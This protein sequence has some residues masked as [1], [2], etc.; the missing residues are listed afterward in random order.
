MLKFWRVEFFDYFCPMVRKVTVLV[1]LLWSF[2]AARAAASLDSLLNALDYEI[3]IA[4]AA[5]IEPKEAM[6]EN[7]RNI[8]EGVDNDKERFELLRRLH[9]EYLYF[10][11]DTAYNY[12]RR[13]ERT[14]MRMGDSVRISMARMALLEC[15][16]S[17][18]FFQE[19][20]KMVESIDI[21]LLPPKER[22]DC[23]LDIAKL[24]QNMESYVAG[25]D[26]LVRKYTERRRRC[27]NAVLALAD[28]DSYS[29]AMARVEKARISRYASPE[30]IT[31]CKNILERHKTDAHQKAINYSTIGLS[32]AILGN[33]DSA[34]YYITL[35]AI[36]DIRSNTRET[37][38]AKDLAGIML[39]R[40]DIE[41]AN[42]YINCALS[43]AET[44]NSRLRKVEINT[45]MPL[46]ET[47]RHNQIS[48]R[49]KQLIGVAIAITLLLALTAFL[50]FK[51]KK[52]NRILTQ[53]HLENREKA[54]ALEESNTALAEAITDLEEAKE[55]KDQY[56]IQSLYSNTDF[57]NEVEEKTKRALLKLKSKQYAEVTGILSDM[58]VRREQERMYSAFDNAFL[59]LFPNFIDELNRLMQP[60]HRIFLIDGKLPTEVRIFA[61]MRLGIDSPVQ[62]AQYL[63]LSVNTVY[64]Y[65]AKFKAKAT[66]DKNEFDRL[67]MSIPK[68]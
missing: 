49:Q 2:A 68:P 1:L 18:G 59:K 11:Y 42:R 20:E 41:R 21:D 37:T 46:I 26:D 34:A 25:S 63:C 14:A 54:Q 30:A 4:K 51:L 23:Y 66:V 29:Y 33:P 22:I 58:G 40:G 5:Y 48:L 16:S 19:A 60:Q 57:V 56:I 8:L 52:R 10:Q 12:A 64:V 32:Y 9:Q 38:A 50:F 13:M 65:K 47:A 17:V 67:V 53:M 61:L 43:D 24:L 7:L 28:P 44:Y 62:I 27:Y 55:I 45:I 39:R 6:L 36:N 15:F 3:G 31:M 35:S